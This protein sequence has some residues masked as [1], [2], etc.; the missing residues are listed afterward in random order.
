MKERRELS[1]EMS[2]ERLCYQP[3]AECAEA[4]AGY[5]SVKCIIPRYG[6]VHLENDCAS[7]VSELKEKVVSKSAISGIVQDIKLALG[8]LPEWTATK[9]NRASNR[10]AHELAKLGRN[11]RNGHVSI[12]Y[13][14]L[15]VVRLTEHYC[16]SLSVL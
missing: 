3:G 8:T 7:L 4:I 12:G 1:C 13:V 5:E 16:N 11:A 9:V 2:T 14:P 15:N 6:P 10:A